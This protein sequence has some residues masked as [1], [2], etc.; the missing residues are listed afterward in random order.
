MGQKGVKKVKNRPFWAFFNLFFRDS[1]FFGSKSAK[2]GPKTAIFRLKWPKMAPKRGVLPPK[3]PF[4]GKNGL[5][6]K[7]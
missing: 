2:K 5:F 3:W 7:K 6:S 1:P 4:L